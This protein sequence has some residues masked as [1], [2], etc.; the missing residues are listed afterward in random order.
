MIGQ[1]PGSGC[2]LHLGQNLPGQHGLQAKGPAL[3]GAEHGALVQ[4]EIVEQ[5]GA[6]EVGA[7]QAWGLSAD[8][9][10]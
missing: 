3:R 10:R 9:R 5:C 6:A 7:P 8:G 4:L 1:I 2:G